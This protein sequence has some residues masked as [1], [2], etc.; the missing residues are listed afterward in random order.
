MYFANPWGFV[1]LL[2]LPAIALI[3]LYHRR[4]PPL[5]IAGL[6][7]WGAEL[8]KESPGRTRERL[9]WTRTLLLELLA[10]LLI[11][12]LLAEPRAGGFDTRPHLV[13]V[14]D[15]SAS[16]AARG[17]HGGESSRDRALKWLKEQE[18]RLGR[19]G[20]FSVLTTGR[21]PTLIAGPRAD[22][23]EMLETLER[24][25]P[26]ETHHAFAPTWDLAAQ[27]AGD[28]GELVFLTDQLP[29]EQTPMPRQMEVRAVGQQQNNVAI[30]AARWLFD[31]ESGEGNLF[32]RIANL[33][34]EPAEVQLQAV[35]KGQAVI[36]E[37]H[38]LSAGA[39]KSFEWILPGGLGQL[40]LQAIAPGDPLAIDH[41]LTLIEPKVRLVTVAVTLPSTHPAFEP[42]RRI[43][44]VMP[45]VQLGDPGS[46]DLI[47]APA[48]DVPVG[49]RGLWW[50]GVGPVRLDEADRNAAKTVIGPYLI[51]KQHPLMN[52]IVLG[53]VVWGGVQTPPSGVTPI[54]STGTSLLLGQWSNLPLPAY[55]LNIDLTA[56]NLSESPDWPIFWTNLVEECRASRPGFRR[57][58]FHLEES[59]PFTLDPARLSEPAPL[60]LVHKGVAKPLIRMEAVQIPPRD[61]IGVYE[62]RDGENSV[63]R[64]AVNFLDREESNLQDL[65]SGVRHALMPN[66]VSGIHWDNP[67]SWLLV[68]GLLVVL[69]VIFSDWYVLR[70][71][72]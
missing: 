30:T 21:R 48:S 60:E 7:L 1:G 11:T 14:L 38:T 46:A 32:A 25:Q 69:L 40:V 68:L 42:V 23:T 3:H 61:S 24:W 45:L 71:K 44:G 9:P 33:G 62:V 10:A 54:V 28:E 5:E 53:G 31:V 52:G 57:W 34:N 51:E 20:L 47:I 15:N 66:T 58:N 39:E 36:K 49:P 26:L 64:F 2:A 35:A 59:I 19:T 41:E 65:S 4:F 56:S 6:H 12:L 50:L 8:R 43:L 17:E 37:T 55:L 27:L 67:F 22:W 18:P 29:P 70:R 13:L 63:G 16:M 72:R